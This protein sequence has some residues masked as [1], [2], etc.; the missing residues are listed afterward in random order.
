MKEA[1]LQY[2]PNNKE[3]KGGVGAEYK[4]HWNKRVNE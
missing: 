4:R 3:T 2:S 1:E